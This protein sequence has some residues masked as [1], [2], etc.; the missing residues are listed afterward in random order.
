MAETSHVRQTIQCSWDR[1][2][3]LVLIIVLAAM[4]PRA[5]NETAPAQMEAT[6]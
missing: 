4:F 1:I 6:E 3:V 5:E 2:L